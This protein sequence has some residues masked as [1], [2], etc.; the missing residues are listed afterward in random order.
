M[1]RDRHTLHAVR[2]DL[3]DR[4]GG[5]RLDAGGGAAHAAVR[6]VV[7]ARFRR[8]SAQ[9]AEVKTATARSTWTRSRA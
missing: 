2:G 7:G 3:L 4:L 5:G 1:G 9:N 8:I 6:G